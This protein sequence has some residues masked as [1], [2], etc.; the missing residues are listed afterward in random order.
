MFVVCIF[1]TLM[2]RR[3][4]PCWRFLKK[5]ASIDGSPVVVEGESVLEDKHRNDGV[6]CQRRSHEWGSLRSLPATTWLD[7]CDRSLALRQ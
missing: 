5:L 4:V 2:A 1:P 3:L 7:C 6:G